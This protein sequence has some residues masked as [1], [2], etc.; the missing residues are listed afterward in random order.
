MAAGLVILLAEDREDDVLVTRKSLSQAFVEHRLIVVGDGEEAIEYL[1]AAGKT[2]NTT[3]YPIPD[4]FLL[5]LKMPR[6]DGFDVLEWLGKQPD[7]KGLRVIV[8]T[9]SE[10]LRDMKIALPARGEFFSG[11]ASKFQ[12]NSPTEPLSANAP[13][14]S[15]YATRDGPGRSSDPSE[16]KIPREPPTQG[17]LQV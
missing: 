2:G 5:D 3:L 14:T 10:S 11:Q 13:F 12:G 4:L 17:P 8:L 7:L 6:K 16:C 15:R 1:K 9:S